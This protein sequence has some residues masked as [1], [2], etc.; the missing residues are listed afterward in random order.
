MLKDRDG[1][2]EERST[3][4]WFKIHCL[5]KVIHY[6]KQTENENPGRVFEIKHVQAIYIEILQSYGYSTESHVSRLADMLKENIPGLE[7]R[8]V[9]KKLTLFFNLTA[10][11]L[12]S[13]SVKD[14]NHFYQSMLDTA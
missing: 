2:S 8:N 14:Y 13:D 9:G 3:E 11:I 1:K 7:L 4:R 12:I 6:I 5:N 10:D